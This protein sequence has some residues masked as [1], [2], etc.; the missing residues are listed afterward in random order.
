ML[1]HM[2]K[3]DVAVDVSHA[4]S[5]H[6]TWELFLWKSVITRNNVKLQLDCTVA[7]LPLLLALSEDARFIA[8]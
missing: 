6:G 3:L 7:S 2:A 4:E 8:L 1:T 5:R